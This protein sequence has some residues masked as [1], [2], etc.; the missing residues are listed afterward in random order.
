MFLPDFPAV[1]LAPAR[2]FQYLRHMLTLLLLACSAVRKWKSSL[3]MVG[4][5]SLT[6]PSSWITSVGAT[7]IPVGGTVKD[8]EIAAQ[9]YMLYNGRYER[10]G[11]SGGGFAINFPAPAYQYE[12]LANYFENFHPPWSAYYNGSYQN[13]TGRYNRDGR[14]FPDISSSELQ[15][16]CL[17]RCSISD[18]ES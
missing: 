4:K 14:G 10:F 18:R 1:R 9:F 13:N 15:H 12:T 8:R 7:Q 17:K 6:D 16:E 3:S 11:S 2:S 5:V